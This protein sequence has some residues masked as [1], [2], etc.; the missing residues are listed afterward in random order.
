VAVD[1]VAEGD[2]LVFETNVGDRVTAGADHPIRVALAPGTGEPAPYVLVRH[3][4]EAR[5][6]RKSFYRLVELGDIRAVDGTD[7]FGVVSDGV[8]F[9]VERAAQ[10]GL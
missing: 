10:I 1:F 2:A 3:G 8:F 5:I 6:D 7:W 4:L 9:P